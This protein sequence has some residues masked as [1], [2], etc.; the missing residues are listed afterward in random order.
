MEVF[1]KAKLRKKEE[2]FSCMVRELFIKIS[3]SFL[4]LLSTRYRANGMKM[5]PKEIRLKSLSART[6]LSM[7]S[8]LKGR[9]TSRKSPETPD[10]T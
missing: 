4:L 5:C 1:I 7:N 3:R 2:K 10:S 9:V 8:C 6:Y